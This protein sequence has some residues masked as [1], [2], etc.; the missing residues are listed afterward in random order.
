MNAILSIAYQKKVYLD[1]FIESSGREEGGKEARR[2][3]ER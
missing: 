2:K 3:R 1:R